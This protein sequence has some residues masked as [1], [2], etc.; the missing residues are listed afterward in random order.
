M[1][2]TSIALDT[3]TK[4]LLDEYCIETGTK[5]SD[6]FRT[7]LRQGIENHNKEKAIG[8]KDSVGSN[9]LMVNEKYAIRAAIEALFILRMTTKDS[10]IL[11]E[12]VQ[13]ADEILKGG[14]RYD[15]K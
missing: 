9:S 7:F 2:K 8:L 15:N 12:A 10:S 3:E 1:I 13:K 6:A 14:W 11:E 5:K 4:K